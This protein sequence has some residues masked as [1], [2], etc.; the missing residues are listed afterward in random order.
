MWPIR[1]R[2]GP[3]GNVRPPQPVACAIA[4]D[5][6][7][8]STGRKVEDHS[9][10]GAKCHGLLP[11][12]SEPR[13]DKHGG[14]ARTAGVHH[15]GRAWNGDRT[16]G[17]DHSHHDEQFNNSGAEFGGVARHGCYLSPVLAATTVTSGLIFKNDFSPMPCTFISSSLF[18][19]PPFFCR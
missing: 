16:E 17:D 15:T 10:V 3:A 6:H 4:T 11:R 7:L 5:T 1:T 13:A 9:D 2:I 19:K 14:L 8:P 18:L 12:H